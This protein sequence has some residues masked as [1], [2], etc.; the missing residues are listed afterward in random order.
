[1]CG[2]AGIINFDST[3]VK[4]ET[5]VEMLGKIRH[6]GPDDEAVFLQDNVGLGF[7]RLSIIDLTSAGKQP[8]Q[9]SDGRYVLVF[10]GEIYNYVEL[11]EELEKEGFNFKTK[12]DTE[13][14]LNS[15]I[16]WGE[17]C[18]NRFNGMWAFAIYD[19]HTRRIFAARD[20][21]GVKPFYYYHSKEQFVFCSEIPPLLS[22]LA[23]KPKPDNNA[24]FNYL[25]FNRTDQDENTFFESIKKLQHGNCLFIENGH[26]SISK[27]Y[28]LKEKIKKENGF[29]SGAEFGAYLEDAIRIRLRSDVPIGV[30]LSGGLDS[31]SIVSV[32][33]NRL[34][35]KQL[36]TFSA[37]YEKG[38]YGDETEFINIYKDIVPNMH[39][40]S[41]SAESLVEDL[42]DFVCTHAEPIPSTSPY[43][44]YKVMQLAKGNVVVTID[45]QGADEHLAGYHYFFGFYFKDLLVHFKWL[46]LMKE[47]Y[48]YLKIHKSFY[49]IKT[50]L[51]FLLPKKIKTLG[52]LNTNRFLRNEFVQKCKGNDSVSG[53]IYASDSLEE[54]LLDHFEYKLEHL[55]KWEDR[56][57]MRFSLEA[58]VPFLDYRLV[59]KSLST[60]A[61]KK[62]RN[63][64]TKFILR[65]AMKDVLPEK[66]RRRQDKIGFGT[67]EDE[68]FRKPAWQTLVNDILNSKSF[69][70]RNIIDVGAAKKLYQ[71]HLKAEINVSKEIWK[72]I[73]LELW[74]REYIDE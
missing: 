22:F 65:E 12:T 72:W 69:S 54:A 59:E 7:V 3:P 37:V 29:K 66:I 48:Y 41:P 46:S 26:L 47:I 40:T 32:L 45:G 19:L 68:W 11:R 35:F 25:V 8:M 20:R 73:H 28:I 70:E 21:F 58:R 2:I 61:D 57:S 24:I 39:Y 14:L 74:F 55:L 18:L 51:Y 5:V 67:P 60:A 10:N 62:I 33:I 53:T 27:W 30:C 1:M 13:V 23:G 9:S 34:Q 52:R 50:F 36:N 43:A 15:Y 71:K 4:N 56:N 6:R 31:S 16:K 44:Q 42:K 38:V 64:V 49:G 63:G 17:D